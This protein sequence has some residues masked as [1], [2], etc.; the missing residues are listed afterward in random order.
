MAREVDDG[1]PCADMAAP[2]CRIS[3]TARARHVGRPLLFLNAILTELRVP[4]P[5]SRTLPARFYAGKVRGADR[6]A[7]EV[8]ERRRFGRGSV[9]LELSWRNERT[10]LYKAEGAKNTGSEENGNER[11]N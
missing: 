10:G 2:A 8:V 6:P 7:E 3:R 5:V 11:W 9:R 1:E 4:C